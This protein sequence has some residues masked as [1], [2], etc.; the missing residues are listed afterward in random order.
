MSDLEK[1]NKVNSAD[2][3]V[4]AAPNETTIDLTKTG[5]EL[6]QQI[7]NETDFEKLKQLETLFNINQAKKSI[8][9]RDT[10]SNIQG[11]ATNELWR[12]IAKNPNE[13]SNQELIQLVKI[14]QDI[15]DR[16]TKK[17]IDPADVQLIQINQN[18]INT[19]SKS[20]QNGLS[21]ESSQKIQRVLDSF[22]A[23][24]NNSN[25]TDMQTN[26]DLLDDSEDLDDER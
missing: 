26:L 3:Q 6:V 17:G 22:L 24:L 18:N 11:A 23:G 16:D 4:T 15:S 7:T 19:D 12:R 21:R 14:M 13:I 1:D 20:A 9:Q 8:E 10:R 2:Y 25:T 5:K